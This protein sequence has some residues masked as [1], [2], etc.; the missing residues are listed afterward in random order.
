MC[1]EAVHN[2]EIS[3][4]D[5]RLG[6]IDL[7]DSINPPGLH[8]SVLKRSPSKAAYDNLF[9]NTISC[10]FALSSSLSK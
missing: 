1:C 5:H 8:P 2:L 6:A 7:A 10:P 4:V 9:C 3:E